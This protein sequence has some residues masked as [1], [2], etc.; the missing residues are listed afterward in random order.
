MLLRDAKRVY[1]KTYKMW[2]STKIY[3]CTDLKCDICPFNIGMDSY[4]VLNKLE[5][6][7]YE[8]E[9]KYGKEVTGLK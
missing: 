5:D 3:F 2:Q 7:M 9:E 4:C 6:A 8:L 1:N